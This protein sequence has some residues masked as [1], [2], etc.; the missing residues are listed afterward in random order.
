[1]RHPSHIQLI[2][3]N[4]E[5]VRFLLKAG[6]AVNALN[7][8]QSSPLH[9]ASIPYNYDGTVNSVPLLL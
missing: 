9:V 2:F 1:M 3:P 6:I 7:Q 5:V 4:V 8:D